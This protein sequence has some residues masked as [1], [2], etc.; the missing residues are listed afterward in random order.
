MK[1][2][3]P[4]VFVLFFFCGAAAA[5]TIERDSFDVGVEAFNAGNCDEALRI[6]KKY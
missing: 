6:M 3:V 5:Q 2:S 1:L 4:F